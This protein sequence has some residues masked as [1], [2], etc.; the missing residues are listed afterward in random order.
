MNVLR[1]MEKSNSVD[2]LEKKPKYFDH[3][4]TMHRMHNRKSVAPTSTKPCASA[5]PLVLQSTSH[6]QTPV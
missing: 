3:F 6:T 5:K 4:E 2:S 1:G